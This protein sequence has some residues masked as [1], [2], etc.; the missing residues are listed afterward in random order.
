MKQTILAKVKSVTNLIVESKSA[1]S[2]CI[3]VCA[4]GCFGFSLST[5]DKCG[6]ACITV[7]GSVFGTRLLIGLSIVS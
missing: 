1:P 4:I 6:S 7:F 5:G 2:K 3:P